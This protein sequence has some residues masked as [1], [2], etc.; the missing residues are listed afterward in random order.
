MSRPL[1]AFDSIAGIDAGTGASAWLERVSFLFLLITVAAAPLSI[2]ATQTAWLIGMAAWLVRIF[3]RPA[4]PVKLGRLDYA[5]WALFAWSVVSSLFS[6]EPAVSI[7]RLRGAAVF[8]I[9]YFVFYNLRTRR[10]IIAVAAVLIASTLFTVGVT[11]TDRAM[12]RGVAM[13]GL[14]ADSALA[15][16][17]LEENDAIHRINGRSVS[18]PDEIV[19]A[20]SE[21]DESSVKA[22]RKDYETDA[23]VKRSDIPPGR[24]GMDALGFADWGRTRNWRASGFYGHYTTYAEVLQLV[25][26]L[27]AGLLVCM[28]FSAAPLPKRKLFAALIISLIAL[29][30]ALLLTVTRA[31]QLS[32]VISGFIILLLGASR[33]WIVAA[34]AIAVP[35]A[36]AALMILRR[37]REVGFFDGGDLSIQY[38]HMMWNDGMRLFLE[39]PRHFLVGVG[40]DSIQKHWQEWGLFDKGWQPM[41]HFHSTP[42]QLMAE[43]GA[44]ALLAFLFIAAFYLRDLFRGFRRK[45]SE[46]RVLAGIVLG[47]LG[48]A[49]GFFVGGLVHYNLG[50][51][52]VAM[53]FFILMALG[54]RAGRPGIP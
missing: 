38:R 10:A 37:S 47:C 35:A 42:V 21:R 25:G 51:Q 26:S 39:S 22:Y 29:G 48:G 28:F 13:H 50:D 17:G 33:K 43:R 32:F 4:V 24:T 11:L 6:Y 52:E 53:V 15:K 5:L 40:M 20:L 19:A 3:L 31:S 8:L 7:D 41:G 45:V 2:A 27:I 16:A 9:F 46:D 14:V 1:A 54:L 12:G 44:P 30:V 34:I 49:I 23:V 18:T 36:A